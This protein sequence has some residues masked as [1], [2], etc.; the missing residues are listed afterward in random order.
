MRVSRHWSRL[1]TNWTATPEDSASHNIVVRSVRFSLCNISRVSGYVLLLRWTLINSHHRLQYWKV[2]DFFSWKFQ[3]LESPGKYPWKLRIFIGFN[4]KKAE[5]V[6]VPVYVD[7]YLFLK[8]TTVNILLHA[9][10]SAMDYTPNVVSKRCFIF[11]FK[12]SWA[13][14]RSRIIYHRVLE[15]PGKVLDFF[16]VKGWEPWIRWYTVVSRMVTFPD[17][18]FPGKTFPG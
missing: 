18:F 15:S 6:N 17:G 11:I 16:P 3:D 4:A 10:V 12:H 7:F 2:L 13:P 9:A 1:P 5:I 8:T 14:K